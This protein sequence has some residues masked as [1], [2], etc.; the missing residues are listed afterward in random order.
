MLPSRFSMKAT[1]KINAKLMV[2]SLGAEISPCLTLLSTGISSERAPQKT[3]SRLHRIM[4]RSNQ[5]HKFLGTTQLQQNLLRVD[6]FTVSN[7]FDK[8]MK[9]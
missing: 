2:N 9:Q 8:S 3:N 6:L 4:K 1:R 5:T 7:G